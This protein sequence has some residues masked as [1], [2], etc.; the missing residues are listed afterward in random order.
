MNKITLFNGGEAV[1]AE[2]REQ[3]ILEYAGNPFIEALPPIYSQDEVVE[4]LSIYPIYNEKERELDKQYKVH[5]VQRLFQVFQP[6]MIHLDLESRISRII[7]Q[8]YLARN[9]F[10][11]KYISTFQEGYDA[12][13]NMNYDLNSNEFFRSTALGLS[14]VGISGIGKTTA[15]NR[16]IGMYPQIIVHSKY[17]NIKFSM[18]QLTWLKIDCP[19]DGS[20]KGLCVDFFLKID[21]L[22]GTDYYRKFGQSRLSVNTMLP[23]MAQV[24]KNCG[25]GVLIIDEIQHLNGAS[26]GG[27][28][29]M[30]NFFV[31]LVNT[32]GVSTIF[33]GTP[34]ALSVL[35]SEFRQARRGSGQGDMVWDRLK[36]DQS[37]ELLLNAIWDY[38]WTRK[39]TP[40][41]KEISDVMYEE[42]QGITDIAVKLYAMSQTRAIISG[43]EEIT[44]D[45]IKEVAS[46]NLRLVKPM[47]DAL[48]TGDIRKIAKYE[49]ISTVDT[50]FLGFIER[51]RQT[52]DLEMKIEALKRTQRKKEQEVKISKKEEVVLKL[53]GL[54]IEADVAQDIVQ[55]ILEEDD[56]LEVNEIVI[57]AIQEIS[58][59]RKKK[60]KVRSRNIETVNEK[61]IRVIVEQGRKNSLSG[62]ESLKEKGIIKEYNDDFLK[63]GEVI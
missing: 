17:K 24:A 46:E 55:K 41:N 11:P 15:I 35:Q 21:S 49:D 23:V 6:L 51:E 38:Q 58:G 14:I 34:K 48:K 54:N 31:K 42:S 33:V 45:L 61:D 40:L 22:L 28:D 36:K 29:K 9:P 39:N 7:R 44:P 25:L 2:Y 12:I 32:F 20:V 10:D 30:L 43:K 1:K 57:K 47:L 63:L 13:Q 16:I 18:Y 19:H 50:D 37:W 62:Y 59:Y 5:I 60:G 8:G 26:S 53:L 56:K 52:I 3:V 27:S 4:K